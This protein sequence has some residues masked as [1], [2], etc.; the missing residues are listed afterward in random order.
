MAKLLRVNPTE[1][2]T[3][4]EHVIENYYL[5]GGRGLTSIILLDEIVPKG[6]P[7]SEKNK[8]VVVP[9]LLTCTKAPD[10]GRLSV[11]AKSPLTGMIKE[12]NAGEFVPTTP[13][14]EP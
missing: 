8:L 14:R 9:G 13:W 4:S 10:A 12:S 5:L 11:A 3:F 1:G 6:E 7:L 2:E